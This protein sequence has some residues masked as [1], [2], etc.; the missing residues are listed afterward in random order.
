MPRAVTE[1][2]RTLASLTPG[3][4]GRIQSF[5]YTSL[6]GL[7][8]DLG[9]HE[10]EVVRCRAGTGG[11]LVLDTADGHSVSLARDWARFIEVVPDDSGPQEGS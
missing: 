5:L 7:L 3:E 4:S 8:S 9:I 6:R 2:S 11:V 1:T 10:G